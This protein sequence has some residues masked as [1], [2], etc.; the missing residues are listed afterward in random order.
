MELST[1]EAARLLRLTE[2]EL[3]R[4]IRAGQLPAHRSRER[5]WLNELELLEWAAERG[6]APD[7]ALGSRW[8]SS[9]PTS[10]LAALE[11]GGIHH[12]VPGGSKETALRAVVERLPLSADHDPEFVLQVLLAREALGSTGI[13]D[14]IA[15]PHV[16]NPLVLRLDSTALMLCFLAEPVEY[17]S[18]DG[19]SVD[20]LFTL[21]TP[22]VRAHL[23]LLSRL[24]FAL[25]DEGFR[26]A[27]RE[28]APAEWILAEV[29]RIEAGLA[30]ATSA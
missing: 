2:S 10:L 24:S 9:V 30:E 21:V 12:R 3:L 17:G 5:Y 26:G 19:R 29:R 25:R 23:H 16:R 15:I 6:V 1:R 28:A 20:V 13:G 18:L 4:W 22:S 11:T 27:L 7:P 8:E 14:G